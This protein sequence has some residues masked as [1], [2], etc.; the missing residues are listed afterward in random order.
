M[1]AYGGDDVIDPHPLC[2]VHQEYNFIRSAAAPVLDHSALLHARNKI[3]YVELCLLQTRPLRHC[4]SFETEGFRLIQVFTFPPY[5]LLRSIRLM[6]F[7]RFLCC[8]NVSRVNQSM[9]FQ[10]VLSRFTCVSY[11]RPGAGIAQSV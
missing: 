6:T 9:T 8:G 3:P 5:S 10:L 11:F 4:Q 7:L 1:K 2:T